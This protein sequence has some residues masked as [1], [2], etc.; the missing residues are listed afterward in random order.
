MLLLSLSVKK[1]VPQVVSGEPL[2]MYLG[3]AK[4][5]LKPNPSYQ[6]LKIVKTEYNIIIR[7]KSLTIYIYVHYTI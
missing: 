4:V 6:T 3:F 2:P 7:V 1:L 5:G